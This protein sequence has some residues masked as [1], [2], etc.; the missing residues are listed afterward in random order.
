MPSGR[1]LKDKYA[2]SSPEN[3]SVVRTL[4][5]LFLS[6]LLASIFFVCDFVVF[7]SLPIHAS[8]TSANSGSIHSYILIQVGLSVGPSDRLSVRPNLLI[9]SYILIQLGRS[10][11]PSVRL[12]VPWSNP[13]FTHSVLPL[14]RR[15]VCSAWPSVG[16]SAW[17]SVGPSAWPSVG[18]SVCSFAS[19]S[20]NLIV[21]QIF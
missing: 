3:A 12:I 2:G 18:P 20:D 6:F 10:A 16:P 21:L 17:P 4:F 5:D 9:H 15:S 1:Q 7:P 19:E 14:V 11:S 8:S 13:Y